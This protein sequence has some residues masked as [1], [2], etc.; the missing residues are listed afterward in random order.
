MGQNFS[1][2]AGIE[3]ATRDGGTDFAYTTSWG[4]STRLIGT[5]I[6]AHGDDD[7]VVLPPRVAPQQVVV[8][9][10][11][12]KED[13]RRAVLEACDRLAA[14]LRAST[15]AGEPV[16]V[17]VDS[18]DLGGGVKNWEW[19]KKGVPV[20]LEVGPRDLEAGTVALARR[21]LGPKEKESVPRPALPGRVAAV[22]QEVQDTLLERATRFRDE[23]TVR[24]DSLDEFVRFFTPANPEKPGTHGGF[25]LCHW[26]GSSED[27]DRLA[28]DHKVTIRCI[29]SG[30]TYLEPGTCFLTGRPS[31]RRLVFAKAY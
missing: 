17:H 19:I 14:E 6:M 22:L 18:R 11:T 4:A 7:G 3:F 10:V 29:P 5:V 9:P 31:T 26:A 25:A 28:R 12:P 21:T 23:H 20:R 24:V 15:F 30:E 13:S 16:R 27:E 1:R 8:L 2:A